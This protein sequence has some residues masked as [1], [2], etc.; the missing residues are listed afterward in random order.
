MK[1]HPFQQFQAAC[2]DQIAR[3]NGVYVGGILVRQG[4]AWRLWKGAVLT[5]EGQ[6]DLERQPLFIEHDHFAVVR[7]I[8]EAERVRGSEK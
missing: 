3:A 6:N 1:E 2:R 5:F 4:E 8:I 7:G